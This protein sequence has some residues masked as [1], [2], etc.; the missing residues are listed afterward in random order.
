MQ[1]RPDSATTTVTARLFVRELDARGL[2]C[3]SALAA[4]GL[5][6]GAV[7]DV[8]GEIAWSQCLR[9]VDQALELAPDDALS[10]LAGT[11]AEMADLDLMGLYLRSTA[12][13]REAFQL[14]GAHRN[15]LEP[16]RMTYTYMTHDALVIALAG[17]DQ[18]PTWA[19]VAECMLATAITL[20]RG[21][22]GETSSIEARFR[23][24]R[25]ANDQAH[26]RVFGQVQFDS[27]LDA[28]FLPLSL[29]DR[30]LPHSDQTIRAVLEP[31]LVRQSQ[32]AQ[33]AHADLATRVLSGIREELAEGQTSVESLA[34]RLRMSPRSLRRELSVLGTS[35]SALLA[36]VRRELALQH[37]VASPRPSGPDIARL[38]G[39]ADAHT[40]YRAFKRWTGISLSAYRKQGPRT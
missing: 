16:S 6:R 8:R 32:L 1:A 34:K 33:A 25:P 11:R 21:T 3:E 40:F 18:S 7:N 27:D 9:L 28:L 17:Q 13:M 29:L 10:V 19:A 14:Y 30:P 31:H 20:I 4:A 39:Y 23:H 5:T 22:L 38:L 15:L 26:T 12:N 36:Q 24:R 2:D 37:A 35:Y